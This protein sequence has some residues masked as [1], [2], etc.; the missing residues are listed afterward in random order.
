MAV[1]TLQENDDMNMDEDVPVCRY[2]DVD[3][4]D[5]DGCEICSGGEAAPRLLCRCCVYGCG[6]CSLCYGELLSD[7]VRHDEELCDRWEMD[8][9]Y[10]EDPTELL[11]RLD[12]ILQLLEEHAGKPYLEVLFTQAELDRDSRTARGMIL[13]G[14]LEGVRR[15]ITENRKLAIACIEWREL[16]KVALPSAP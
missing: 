11:G 2:E 12:L 6:D 16:A 14:H 3:G 5:H 7:F 8:P 9:K 1:P 4:H 15:L 10:Y 13:R